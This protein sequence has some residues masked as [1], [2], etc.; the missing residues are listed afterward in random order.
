MVC[1]EVGI[2]V[3]LRVRLRFMVVQWRRHVRGGERNRVR[4]GVCWLCEDW[5]RI[6]RIEGTCQTGRRGRRYSDKG[7]SNAVEIVRSL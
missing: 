2:V 6:E 7:V 5:A 4:R 1:V 3:V